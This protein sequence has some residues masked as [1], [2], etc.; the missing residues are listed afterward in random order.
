[1][2]RPQKYTDSDIAAAIQAL[3][4][5]GEDVNPMRVR[6]RLG[7]GNVRRI[8]AVLADRPEAVPHP[9]GDPTALPEALSR[10]VQLLFT[11]TSQQITALAQKCWEAGSVESTHHAR[12]ENDRLRQEIAG[13]KT[14][15][16]SSTDLVGRLE[17]QGEEKDRVLD[18]RGVENTKLAQ[19]SEGLR[20]ALRNAESDLRASQR[21]IDNL[22]RNQ[23]QDRE[24]IRALQKRIEGL[25]GEIAV[26]KA[27]SSASKL[28]KAPAT[29]R[30]V[31]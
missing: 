22:E 27:R 3:A 5:E 18:D 17:R 24:E 7:G 6:M 19:T 28:P 23:G 31:R 25:V 20:A 29:R 4:D 21:V 10:E 16:A 13:L 11:E 12:R 2:P 1:M 9:H 8:K 15:L 30:K 26:L 14:S